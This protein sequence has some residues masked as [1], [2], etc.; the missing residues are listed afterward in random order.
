L[1]TERKQFQPWDTLPRKLSFK[2][3]GRIK[4]LHDKQKIIQYM[5]TKPQL[6]KIMKK[7]PHTEDE[8]KYSNERMLLNLKRTTDK[9]LKSSI[10]LVV[11][12]QTPT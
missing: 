1:S 4:T 3:E 5:N 9:E 2:I 7:I 8:N 6:Q 12:I 10:E 11:H